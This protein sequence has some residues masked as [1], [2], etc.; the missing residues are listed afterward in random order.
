MYGVERQREEQ[1]KLNNKNLLSE[2]KQLGRINYQNRVQNELTQADKEK[3]RIID[4]VKREC[5]MIER[6]K[7]LLCYMIRLQRRCAKIQIKR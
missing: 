3:N 1:R 2:K 7:V 5:D 4:L 6:I